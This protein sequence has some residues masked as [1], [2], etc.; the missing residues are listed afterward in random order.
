MSNFDVHLQTGSDRGWEVNKAEEELKS[1]AESHIFAFSLQRSRE[2]WLTSVFLK[3][4]GKAK[5]GSKVAPNTSSAPPPHDL[6]FRGKCEVEIGPHIFP[7]TTFHEALYLPTFSNQAPSATSYGGFSTTS[8]TSS[9]FEPTIATPALIDQINAAA[10]TNPILAS[11]L[12]LA[13]AGQATQ[14]QLQMLSV[15]IRSLAANPIPTS[16]YSRPNAEPIVTFALPESK[17]RSDLVIT[18]E[19]SSHNRF[20]F[21]RGTAVCERVSGSGHDFDIAVT[22]YVQLQNNESIQIAVGEEKEASPSKPRMLRM[23]LHGASESLWDTFNR[24]IG[25]EEIVKANKNPAQS[26]QSLDSSSQFLAESTLEGQAATKN[27][28]CIPASRGNNSCSTPYPMKYLK[29]SALI[30]KSKRIRKTEHINAAMDL[31]AAI[32]GTGHSGNHTFSDLTRPSALPTP[33]TS[34]AAASTG[35][36][37][38][39]PKK[40]NQHRMSWKTEKISQPAGTEIRCRSCQATDVPLMLGGRF[41]RPCVEAGRATADI[42]QLPGY[43]PRAPPSYTPQYI[44]PPPPVASDLYLTLTIASHHTS[45]NTPGSGVDALGSFTVSHAPDISV[46]TPP[47]PQS[48]P[49]ARG[50]A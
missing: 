4:T 14:D 21:P 40:R 9:T 8:F 33:A 11:L 31:A 34:L 20:I 6:Q 18:F 48:D 3:F 50:G 41:C 28:P 24:W 35:S 10:A 36:T 19:E 44:P 27:L 32:T 16:Q 25:G 1:I 42:P 26:C 12:Q 23:T 39:P 13:S 17:K 49:S 5:K 43:G 7:N 22:S 47:K 29:P 2:K 15:T 38:L 30:P 37:P 46:E 45:E